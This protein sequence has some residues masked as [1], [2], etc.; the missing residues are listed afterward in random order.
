M[1]SYY[2]AT[3][4]PANRSKITS[5]VLRAE[6]AAVAAGISGKL[7][8]LA[9][10]GLEVW[11]TN[12]GGTAAE[13]VPLATLLST[14]TSLVLAG[15]LSGVTDLTTTGNTILG[16]AV[17]DTFNVGAG[18]IVKDASGNTTFGG[19][20]TITGALSSVTDITS[21]G[22]TVLGNATTDTFNVGAGGIVKD[23]LGNTTF[24]GRV[25]NIVGSV[26]APSISFT[27]TPT[28]G[29]YSPNTNQFGIATA[30]VLAM[31]VD[32]AQNVMIGGTS[33]DP[34]AAGVNGF[35]STG[36]A[37]RLNAMGGPAL[38]LGR[39]TSDGQCVQFF[40]N[41]LQVGNISVTATSTAFNTSSDPRLKNITGPLSGSGAFID[42]LKPW[43]G[44]WRVD[45]SPFVGFLAHEV[46]DVASRAVLGQKNAVDGAGRPVYQSMEYGSPEIITNIVAELQSL[47]KRIASAGIL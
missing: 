8:T 40:R 33:S 29:I 26:G 43:V 15:T 11:R 41:G 4:Q 39:G 16:N 37:T 21:T 17:A 44:T 28:T 14:L 45:G 31:I 34:I 6:F 25:L 46:Q 35:Q 32:G 23:S 1:T 2:D 3:G 24:G 38:L 10:H 47:R 9:A 13:S 42:A 7:P 18:G 36:S 19:G 20:V 22:N 12:A 27:G 5:S 30:G